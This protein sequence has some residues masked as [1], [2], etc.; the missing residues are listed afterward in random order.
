MRRTS[1]LR[2][3]DEQLAEVRRRRAKKNPR[4]GLLA[5][6][7]KRF[8]LASGALQEGRRLAEG[9]VVD[10]ERMRVNLDATRGLIFADAVAARLARHLG[11]GA[12]R[13][14]GFSTTPN[15]SP[16]SPNIM[17]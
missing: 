7:R 3:T 8:G 12:A 14:A 11:R 6:A 16:S 13:H 1:T 2:L 5:D 10:A 15:P 4:Y 9:L 17:S